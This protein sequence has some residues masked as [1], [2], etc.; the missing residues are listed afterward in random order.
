MN[1]SSSHSG[2]DTNDSV[3]P[4]LGEGRPD[5]RKRRKSSLS[6]AGKGTHRSVCIGRFNISN[7][8]PAVASIRGSDPARHP[9]PLRIFIAIPPG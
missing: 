5:T 2:L 1:V 8:N 9:S 6:S 7:L 4:L 3:E